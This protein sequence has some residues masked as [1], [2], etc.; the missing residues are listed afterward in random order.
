MYSCEI[1]R[2]QLPQ[3]IADGEPRSAGYGS[4]RAHLGACPA[5]RAYAERLR[6]VEE[7]LRTYPRVWPDPALT[8]RIMRT[9]AAE[10]QAQEESWHLLTWDVWLPVAA[11]VLTLLIVVMSAPPQVLPEMPLQEFEGTIAGW[12]SNINTWVAPVLPA[13]GDTFWAI[14]SG[15]FVALA[16]L[17]LSLSLSC[18]N[19]LNSRSLDRLE[20]H[21]TEVVSRLRGYTRRVH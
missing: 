4:L 15:L 14:W 21:V 18:W 3:Y 10:K 8:M 20:E 2:E 6:V 12:H 17:G 19:T 5:C 7:A 1:A 13:R 11:L 9:V 16:G